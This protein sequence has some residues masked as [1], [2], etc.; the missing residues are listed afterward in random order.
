M[1][2]LFFWVYLLNFLPLMLNINIWEDQKKSSKSQSKGMAR[3]QFLAEW[4]KNNPLAYL[5]PFLSSFRKML[6]WQ[7]LTTRGH[8]KLVLQTGRIFFRQYLLM[9]AEPR[10]QG[11]QRDSLCSDS[12]ILYRLKVGSP[13]PDLT[14]FVLSFPILS[15][16][17]VASWNEEAR[18][19]FT[20]FQQF[21]KYILIT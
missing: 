1:R 9:E 18:C 10:A 19:C 11:Y 8:R 13:K 14:S 4:Y 6:F 21:E 3:E 12:S 7:L 20:F 2:R 16:L 15:D 17:M 5:F